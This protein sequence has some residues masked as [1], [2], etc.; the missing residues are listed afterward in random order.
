[1]ELEALQ[2]YLEGKGSPLTI[3]AGDPQLPPQLAA[4]LA[5]APKE[6]LTLTPGSGGI[7]L[8]GSTLTISGTSADAWPL[9]GMASTELGL[10]EATLTVVDSATPA[11]S[12]T[13]MATMPVGGASAQVAVSSP[14]NPE[15]DW[16]LAL[17]ADVAGVTPQAVLDLVFGWELPF[18]PPPQLDVL[19]HSLVL[20]KTGFSVA[21]VPGSPE[22]ALVEFAIEAPEA[23]L[24][25]LS[26]V[27]ELDGLTLNGVVKTHS[28]SLSVLSHL[29]ID[30]TPVDLGVGFASGSI[31][32]A[33]VA[34]PPGGSFPGIKALADWLAGSDSSQAGA[35]SS[36]F[37]N[38]KF[39]EDKFD[40]AIE[41]ISLTFDVAAAK[42]V[43]FEVDSKLTVAAVPLDVT[44]TLPD[45]TVAG[46]LHEG[47]AVKI[48]DVL[49]AMN[50][51]VAELPLDTE[52]DYVAFSAQPSTSS[53]MAEL[54][55]KEVAKAGPFDLEEISVL[56]SY[57]GAE[58]FDGRFAAQMSFW[59]LGAFDA[60]AEYSS[61]GGW[62]WSV[63]TPPG[64]GVELGAIVA[65]LGTEFQ[66]PEDR[67]PK[68]I[69]TLELHSLAL[70]LATG[71]STF[72]FTFSGEFEVADTAIEIAP[73]IEIAPL[74]PGDPSKGW[75]YEFGGTLTV[76]FVE[77]TLA[78]D[79]AAGSTTFVASL[80]PGAEGNPAAVD[81]AAFVK[82]IS[83]TLGSEIPASLTVGLKSAKLAS[84]APPTGP[85]VLALALDLSASIS[86]S[87]L[88]LVGDE[89]PPGESVSIEDLQISYAS[90]AVTADQLKPVNALLPT[91]VQFPAAGL[92]EGAGVVATIAIAGNSETLT[93]GLAPPAPP[94]TALPAPGASPAP[95]A[96]V[97]STRTPAAPR[98]GAGET[99]AAA[100]TAKWF[101]VQRQ[102]G[103]VQFSRVGVIYEEGALFFAIDAA[104]AAG[105]LT[106]SVDGLGLGSKLTE[107]APAFTLS[108]AG[109]EF[110][111]PPL[112]IGGALLRIVPPPA[113]TTFEL[114]GSLTIEAEQFAIGAV[115][116]YAVLESGAPSLFVF[117]Q[118][119]MPLG[120]P[121]AFFVTGLMAGFGVNRSLAIPAPDE[122]A[123]FP[124][125]TLNEP[126]TP[127]QQAKPQTLQ[128]VLD[129]IEGRQPATPNGTAREWIAPSPGTYWLAAGL[130][131][132]HF[133]LVQTRALLVLE[134]GKQ[135]VLAL[136]GLAR[137]QLPQA[138]DSGAT[139]A[140]AELQIEA[141]LEPDEGY[142][143]L[144]A[145]L[146]P[147]SYVLVPACKVTGGFAFAVWFGDSPHAGQFVLTVGG[148]HPA[149]KPPDYFPTV[150]RLGFSWAVSSN[151]SISGG[152]YLAVTPSAA[153]AGGNLAALFQDGDLRAWFTANAD[154]LIA[155][156]PFSFTAEVAVEVGVSYRLNL[157]FCHKTI[158]ISLGASV[159]LW[160]P[161]TGGIVHVHLWC[162]S[163]SVSFGSAGAGAASHALVW[164]EF[165]S[166]LPASGAV[167]SLQPA[168]GLSKTEDSSASS[169]G[170]TWFVRPGAFAFTTEAAIPASHLCSGEEEQGKPT[171]GSVSS[172]APIDVRPMNMAGLTAAHRLIVR[173]GSPSAEPHDLKGW[174]LEPRSRNLPEALWG[175]PPVPFTQ[176]PAPKAEALPAQPV[177]FAVSPPEPKAG[178]TR[179]AFPAEELAED[180]IETASLPLDP[181]A[182]AS[183]AYAPTA[184]PGSVGDISAI[185]AAAPLRSGLV[186]ALGSLYIGDDEPMTELG[187]EAATLFSEAPMEEVTPA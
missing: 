89:L 65:K 106:I 55:V 170:K 107:F 40:A 86:L 37:A 123:G 129:V 8:N 186:N 29:E 52:I 165:A 173:Q 177:G 13:A 175:T 50:L 101:D 51:P 160:G 77:L 137:L 68:P 158:E 66:L 9:A 23:K 114:D 39:E 133:E 153:M 174:S 166:L 183:G 172:A 162:V 103:P 113:G 45:L 96:G 144:T 42:L 102:L 79:T 21:F 33:F 53:Y 70:T 90:A 85:R 11:I 12:L 76:A 152:A 14:P 124:L 28:I 105:P 91:A 136:L 35:I 131:A 83:P 159:Q 1:M 7:S 143:G 46:S 72:A 112:R 94:K 134:L 63:M 169:S 127:G 31:W 16:T 71:T 141:V 27:V 118:L 181:E 185:A 78:F 41:G 163:F 98:A 99:P 22:D 142:F 61:V 125:L 154:L 75:S 54:H 178:A 17:A 130:M 81:V 64:G 97:P 30:G 58:G 156:R 34:P 119:T 95:T 120:G 110:E 18:D 179:G 128:H 108:G 24:T 182:G 59:E 20:P 150:P 87:D 38:V 148:Y 122:V 157:L 15:A 32:S 93:L 187:E 167:V 138:A 155:W 67:I 82:E 36:G 47:A 49:G 60:S 26:G 88:P 74:V 117:G 135:P 44:L 69:R 10:S 57:S 116:S 184:A 132:T 80:E 121:P 62:T 161:P 84:I 19:T 151:V 5:G 145:I 4:F 176:T 140:Y 25:V 115:G 2:R 149:F 171:S 180:T 3:A 56:A 126:E 48:S 43:S 147:A 111:Q 168:G 92:A 146:T 104:L 6:E 100:P 73:K 139:Y 164:S 109:V